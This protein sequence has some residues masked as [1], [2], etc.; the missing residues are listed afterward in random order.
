MF[1]LVKQPGGIDQMVA[2]LNAM[3]PRAA[4]KI[5]REFKTPDEV[6]LATELLEKLRIFGFEAEAA[7]LA[8]HDNRNANAQSNAAAG[9]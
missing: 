3:A 7:E 9:G 2:Y 8:S 4:N 6:V 5:L 1:E